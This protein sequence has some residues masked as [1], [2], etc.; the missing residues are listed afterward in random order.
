[1]YVAALLLKYR[2]MDHLTSIFL[3]ILAIAVYYLYTVV[4]HQRYELHKGVP[5]PPKSF[6]W[7]HLQLIGKEMGK[8]KVEGNRYSHPDYALYNIYKDLPDQKGAVA[9]DMWPMEYTML[10]ITSHK[11]AEQ[12]SRPSKDFRYGV[13]KSP[14]MHTF[15]GLIG[16]ESMLTKNVRSSLAKYTAN[17]T[18]RAMEDV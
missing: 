2:R 16:K 17:N 11:I 10:F 15:D 7:G 3:A 9:L 14:T 6:L 5:E 4:Y 1:V 12:L 18:G 13:Y 8:T